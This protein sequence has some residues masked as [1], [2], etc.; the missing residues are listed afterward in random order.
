MT[1]EELR[2]ALA[3]RRC[4]VDFDIPEEDGGILTAED[5][6]TGDYVRW[7]D[8]ERALAEMQAYEQ[9]R[10]KFLRAYAEWREPGAPT[11]AERVDPH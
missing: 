8:V 4:S 3:K 1:V 5:D 9:Y 10:E 7:A 6:A 2:A 11:T